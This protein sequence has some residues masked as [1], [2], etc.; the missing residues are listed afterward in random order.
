MASLAKAVE[1]IYARSPSITLIPPII[2][3]L[4]G[5]WCHHYLSI[6][7]RVNKNTA[8]CTFPGQ[9]MLIS[10]NSPQISMIACIDSLQQNIIVIVVVICTVLWL[11][12][13]YVH[14]TPI[15]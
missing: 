5:T 2:I 12:D 11:Q 13:G 1:G 7:R 3:V 10:I 9:P 8:L 15:V 4:S 6:A 14:S